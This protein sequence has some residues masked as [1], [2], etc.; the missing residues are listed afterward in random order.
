M[1]PII[2]LEPWTKLLQLSQ[3]AKRRTLDLQHG[4]F[5]SGWHHY[6]RVAR[7]SGEYGH[8]SET[9]LLINLADLVAYSLV[10]I[11][12]NIEF[13]I[14]QNVE[15]VPAPVGLMDD[16]FT[17]AVDQQTRIGP[18]LLAGIVPA[19]D[20]QFQVQLVLEMILVSLN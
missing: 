4:C 13:A 19:I 9:G 12:V 17:G 14:D 7:L 20:N 6:G 3:Q 10:I 5:G 15:G 2:L 16:L 1:F 18:N 8:F 11:D